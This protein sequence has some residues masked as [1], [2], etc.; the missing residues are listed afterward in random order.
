MC[1]Q[2]IRPVYLPGGAALPAPC[3]LDWV[4][5]SGHSCQ[6]SAPTRGTLL[7]V[8]GE[9]ELAMLLRKV[10]PTLRG[11]PLLGWTGHGWVGGRRALATGQSWVL[12]AR[13]S[14][15]G[16]QSALEAHLGV[17]GI[18]RPLGLQART[19]SVPVP[20]VCFHAAAL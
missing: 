2:R 19:S 20:G 17:W 9:E 14:P 6:A 11:N 7:Q 13:R 15:A 12:L 5:G 10:A 8:Q 16:L 4:W 3:L 1:V 18:A